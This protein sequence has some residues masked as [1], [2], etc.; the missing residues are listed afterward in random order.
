M[1][2]IYQIVFVTSLVL[3][4][5]ARVKRSHQSN[6]S[7]DHHQGNIQTVFNESLETGLN[8][9]DMVS[10]SFAKHQAK[11]LYPGDAVYLTSGDSPW[12]NW[13]SSA[14]RKSSIFT[15]RVPYGGMQYHNPTPFQIY[16]WNSSR[17]DV[18]KHGDT[19]RIK[20][21]QT[22]VK[23]YD[24]AAIATKGL[25]GIPE[26]LWFEPK[27]SDIKQQWQI[28]SHIDDGIGNPI[29][30]GEIPAYKDLENPK[31]QKKVFFRSMFNQFLI[32]P[33]QG[34]PYGYANSLEVCYTDWKEGHYSGRI[35]AA[36]WV[37][38]E[39]IGIDAFKRQ[40]NWEGEF[41]TPAP[42]NG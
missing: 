15:G 37:I 10:Q 33:D 12:P 5:A 9:S 42:A 11:L 35:A 7:N 40:W 27:A 28:E 13:H 8:K 17:T 39:A 16:H 14:T 6:V 32:R 22:S 41:S 4:G 31:A 20:T 1:T 19:V 36:G 25:K 26:A 30:Y 3:S 2:I 34:L 23:G 24:Y 29:E 21:L 18:I 38:S